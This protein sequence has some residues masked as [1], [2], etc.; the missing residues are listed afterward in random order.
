MCYYKN[1]KVRKNTKNIERQ[2]QL[3]KQDILPRSN[4]AIG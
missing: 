1:T 2:N 3:L 4:I